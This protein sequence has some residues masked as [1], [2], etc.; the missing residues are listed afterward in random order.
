MEARIAKGSN[1]KLEKQIRQLEKRLEEVSIQ[2]SNPL[3]P[4]K[5]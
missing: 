5:W 4:D 3:Q 1:T 2:P